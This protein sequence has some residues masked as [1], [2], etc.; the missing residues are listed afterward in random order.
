LVFWQP[1]AAP[2]FNAAGEVL[3]DRFHAYT[4]EPLPRNVT[5]SLRQ[6]WINDL[7]NRLLSAN[8]AAQASRELLIFPPHEPPI[9]SVA[10]STSGDVWLRREEI[11]KTTVEY[12]V[13]N[14]VG[15][16]VARVQLP[17]AIIVRRIVGDDV[18]AV[19]HGEF[20]I[21]YVVRYQIQ[22]S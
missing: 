14:P 1:L 4:P 13:L 17:R 2:Q 21:P 20:D 22:R 16:P 18:Y 12:I 6:G 10:T 8:A 9:S 19:T 15:T 3:H 11:G 5:D 7:G